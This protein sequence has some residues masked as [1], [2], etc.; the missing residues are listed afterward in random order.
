MKLAT[1]LV[2]SDQ[3]DAEF[4]KAIGVSRQ[5]LWRYK[6]GRIPKP[7]VMSKIREATAGAVTSLD[8]YESEAVQ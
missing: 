7:S 3:K 1:W 2:E 4:A 6:A 8:F 5:A